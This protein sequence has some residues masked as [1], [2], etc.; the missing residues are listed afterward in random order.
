MD[1]IQITVWLGEPLRRAVGQVRIELDLSAPATL[2]DLLARLYA[3]FP[4]FSARYE[5]LDLGH[6]HPYRLFINHRQVEENVFGR[7]ELKDGDLVH[8]VIPVVGGK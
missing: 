6:E 1:K 4:D 5:G 3:A 2:A 7:R 8:I